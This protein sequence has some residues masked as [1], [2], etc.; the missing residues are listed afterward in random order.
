MPRNKPY[1]A[2]PPWPPGYRHQR[3]R[4]WLSFLLRRRR[5]AYSLLLAIAVAVAGTVAGLS[6]TGRTAGSCRRLF[7]PAYF[8]ASSLWAQADRSG[9]A[10]GFMILDI[11]GVGA[12]SAPVPHFQRLVRQARAAGVTI[13]GYSST[14]DGQRPASAVEADVRNYK[15]WYGVTDIMLDEVSGFPQQ[16]GYYRQ[17]ASYIHGVNP[18]SSVWMNVGTY[19]QDPQYMSIGNVMMV[20][21]GTYAQY[22][23]IQV[24]SWAASYPARRFANTVYATPGS[25]LGG[26]LALAKQR[27]AGY[28]YVTDG[29]G[30]NPYGALPG[31]WSAEVSAIAAGCG[32]QSRPAA[33]AGAPAAVPAGQ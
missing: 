32:G 21:E 22:R 24:P 18:G 31:Y 33:A 27:N 7:V 28:V 2:V 3:L 5:L 1:H 12:G 19:P 20:F 13:L 14:A 15:A 9:A 17:I 4:R 29:T 8:Y 25:D 23:D 16:A 6:L 30:G 26:A 10:L 11:S